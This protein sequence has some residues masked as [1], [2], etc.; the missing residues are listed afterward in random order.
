MNELIKGDLINYIPEHLRSQIRIIERINKDYILIET[1]YGKHKVQPNN[2]KK[3]IRLPDSVSAVHK[4]FYW[5]MRILEV[6]PELSQIYPD[7]KY[8]KF[9]TK[10]G[11]CHTSIKWDSQLNLRKD[12]KNLNPIV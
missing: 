2:L 3:S 4:D 8:V 11:N 1:K 10:Y 6:H 5:I 9:N 12:S 7:Q